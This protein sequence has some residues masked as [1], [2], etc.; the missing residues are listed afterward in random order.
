MDTI[1][2]L[3]FTAACAMACRAASGLPAFPGA[4]G[5]GKYTTGGRGG[6]VYHVTNLNDTGPGSL[7]D[8]VSTSN[9]IVVFDVGGVINIT[10]RIVIKKN[11]YIAGQTAPGGG[12]TIYRNGVALNGDS[13]NNIIRYIRIR[14][15]KNGD[16][17]KDALA[18]SA[19]QNYMLDHVSISWGIDG[20]LDVNGDGIDNLTFQN[21]IIGQ[22]I[23]IDNHSTGGLMQPSGVEGHWSMIR[24]LYIDNKTRNPK[25]RGKHEFVNSVLYNWHEHGYIMGDT[26]NGVSECNLIGNYFI[27]GPSSN[28]NTHITGTTSYFHVYGKDN[29][30]DDNKN[31]TVDGSLMTS[32]KTAT[33]MSSPFNYPGVDK[34]LSAQD[35]LNHVIE[36]VGPSKVRDAVD[37]FLIDELRSYGK[38]GAIVTTEDE[39]GIPN[40]VGTVA[41]G[42]PPVDTDKDGMPDDWE[43]KHGLNPDRADDCNGKEL[44]KDGYT[45]IEMYIN[46]L[47]GDPVVF[48]DGKVSADGM[49]PFFKSVNLY[50]MN[51][52]GAIEIYSIQGRLFYK[53]TQQPPF[54]PSGL[55]IVVEKKGSGQVLHHYLGR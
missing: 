2:A 53:G 20:T 41:N 47:A 17:K 49:Q 23:N 26:E 15:G 46:E 29:W 27:Y 55:S 37:E 3:C 7:R 35:A 6:A 11:V 45:N 42:T 22:G 32:Y 40:N 44:S 24:S 28:S 36:N 12:I 9:R 52:T 25:A 13:G 48:A 50:R 54:F 31:G 21:C 19:G 30:V 18:V 38:K 8:A 1:K 33:V 5:F 51:E 4:E 34:L 16:D 10:E 43:K 14:M 39:N